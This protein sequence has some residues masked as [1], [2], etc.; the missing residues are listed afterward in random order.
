M[1]GITTEAYKFVVPNFIIEELKI[2]KEK[3]TIKNG[4]LRFAE[5]LTEIFDDTLYLQPSEYPKHIDD[6]LIALVLAVPFKKYVMTQDMALKEKFLQAGLSV[7][8]V[9]YGKAK[10]LRPEQKK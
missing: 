9:T 2:V 10:L 4:A 7:I 6:R 8:L 3:R 5:E 1:H